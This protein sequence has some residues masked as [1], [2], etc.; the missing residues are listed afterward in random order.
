MS[1]LYINE[2]YVDESRGYRFGESGWYETFT[3]NKN[4]LFKH[5]RRE[6]GQ[7]KKM[8]IGDG[9]QVG[10]VF[11][12]NAKYEDTG[13]KYKR[14]VWVEVSSTPVNEYTKQVV[15]NITSAF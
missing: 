15:E 9:E 7:A 5:L 1:N 8:Y 12:G 6:Y 14:S 2:V 10:W 11:T 4:D 13:E 3:D